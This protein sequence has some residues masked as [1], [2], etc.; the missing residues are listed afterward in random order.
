MAT[1]VS[2]PSCERALR[3]PDDLLGALVKCPSCQATFTAGAPQ[4][5]PRQEEAP[6]EGPSGPWEGGFRAGDDRPEPP[7]P[8]GRRQ[9]WEDDRGGRPYPRP[10]DHDE[11]YPERAR[12]R[13]S[14]ARALVGGPA[15]GLMVV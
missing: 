6:R 13:L 10:R 5:P 9:D 15:I 1:E 14:D 2:C 8:F 4:P 7:R 12:A 3:V 11:D